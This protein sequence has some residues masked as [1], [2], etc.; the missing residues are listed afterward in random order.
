MVILQKQIIMLVKV[1]GK[2]GVK[3]LMGFIFMLIRMK[4]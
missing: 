3:T 1:H 4:Q 2:A